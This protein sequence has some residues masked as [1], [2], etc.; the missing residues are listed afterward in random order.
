MRPLLAYLIA[1]L[2]GLA[3]FTAI[4]VLPVT[5]YAGADPAY[6]AQLGSL[7]LGVVAPAF[8]L[9]LALSLGVMY[10]V[11]TRFGGA[12]WA[13]AAGGLVTHLGAFALLAL[14]LGFA[15]VFANPFWLGGLVIGG[16]AHGLVFR[17]AVGP[18]RRFRSV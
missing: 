3:L 13:A 14:K 17:A 10:G 2:A 8:V 16:L 5:P 12:W 18:G 11:R 4:W 7:V 6:L 9:V 1:P 15:T